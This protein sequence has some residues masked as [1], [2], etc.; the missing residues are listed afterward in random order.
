MRNIQSKFV[1]TEGAI[2]NETFNR[3]RVVCHKSGHQ[4]I[5]VFLVVQGGLSCKIIQ[6]SCK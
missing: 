4:V 5:V 3:R 2:V 6:G 1:L